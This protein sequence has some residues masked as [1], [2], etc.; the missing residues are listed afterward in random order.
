MINNQLIQA[1]D[2]P[3]G[4]NTEL[5]GRNGG[6]FTKRLGFLGDLFIPIQ[7]T[8]IQNNHVVHDLS[9]V[10]QGIESLP[11]EIHKRTLKATYKSITD[12]FHNIQT[13]HPDDGYEKLF[14]LCE[15]ES[16][17]FQTCLEEQLASIDASDYSYPSSFEQEL[18]ELE[19]V[20]EA[21]VVVL[22]LYLHAATKLFPEKITNENTILSQ[23]KQ[24]YESLRNLLR[25]TLTPN[26]N[27]AG[28]LLL[29]SLVNKDNGNFETYLE[30]DGRYSTHS[31]YK[32]LIHHA[33]TE[34]QYSR[35][36]VINKPDSG[37]NSREKMLADKLIELM[38]SFDILY[39]IRMRHNYKDND[40]EPP[41]A[42]I[43]EIG[44]IART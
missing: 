38:K 33:N 15:R 19:V 35:C 43:D 37:R 32:A 5:F 11:L 21:Y 40:Q 6:K 22:A 17:A 2:Q 7:I 3:I 12:K 16:R 13:Y 41:Q 27:L 8:N 42:I 28:S 1:A 31:G 39:E 10:T 29:E 34:G 26:Q 24:G 30:Y 25:K 36:I 20:C 23:I 4:P 44:K 9:K 14:E 18:S